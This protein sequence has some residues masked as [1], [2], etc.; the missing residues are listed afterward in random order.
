MGHH[1]A[2]SEHIPPD[3]DP[4]NSEERKCALALANNLKYTREQPD[5]ISP[6]IVLVIN[7]NCPG[8]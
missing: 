6:G 2:H 7:D 4:L 8:K 1:L 3:V 5:P